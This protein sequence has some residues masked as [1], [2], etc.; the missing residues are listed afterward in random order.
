MK[1]ILMY[2]LVLSMLL[3]ALLLVGCTGTE[4]ETAGS[5]NASGMGS[6]SASETS[7][8]S[9]SAS[10]SGMGTGETEAPEFNYESFDFKPYITLASS[11]YVGKE[12]S[13]PYDET[14]PESYYGAKLNALLMQYATDIK[15][16]DKA[17]KDGDTVN[18]YYKGVVIGEDGSETAFDG[19][20]YEKFGTPYPL[21]LGSNSFIDGFEE[22][23]VGVLPTDTLRVRETGVITDED[24]ALVSCTYTSKTLSTGKESTSK[25]ENV[26][27]DFRG[28]VLLTD[29]KNALLGKEVGGTYTVTAEKDADKNGTPETET[30]YVVTVHGLLDLSTPA[31]VMATFPTPYP[32]SPDL[33]GKTVKFYVWVES[34]DGKQP[35]VFDKTFVLEKLKYETEEEDVLAAFEREFRESVQKAYVSECRTAAIN[36]VSDHVR[37]VILFHSLP[38]KA[39]LYEY[40]LLKEEAEYY[41][42]YYTKAGYKLDSIEDFIIAYYGVEEAG[43][44]FSADAWYREN[45]EEILRENAIYFYLCDVLG[46]TVSEEEVTEAV[47]EF[48]DEMIESAKQS[49]GKTYT[50]E[51]VYEKC[52]S[53]YG[54]GYIEMFYRDSIRESRLNDQLYGNITVIYAG[55]AAE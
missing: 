23:L 2:L 31:S 13:I 53:Y 5:E 17:A 48:L 19:G 16:T 24:V 15:V 49:E 20:T 50:R 37:E 47:N 9:E 22:G 41:Y 1:K 55:A 12:I 39:V 51:E 18:I 28:D 6:E 44:D 27:F 4:N 32:N 45:A 42:D 38:E 3:P 25:D 33:A 46:V 35:P 54:E 43:E 36:A 14:M 52:V 7:D 26:Y 40:T 11:E 34:I 10:E 30:T 21:T 8:G 29:L